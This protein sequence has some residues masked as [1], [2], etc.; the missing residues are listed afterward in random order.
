MNPIQSLESAA[1]NYLAIFAMTGIP[2]ESIYKG[3]ENSSTI[4][5]STKALPRVVLSADDCS[6]FV[7]YTGNYRGTLDVTVEASAFDTTDQAFDTIVKE[8]FEKFA[9]SDLAAQL[10]AALSPFNCFDARA[11][12]TA[13]R[14]KEGANWQSTLN[15][16]VHF[17]SADLV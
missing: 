15:I 3:I 14:I 10:S 9:V 13:H 16:D 12:S 11:M 6:E 17:C 1:F 5:E 4:D 2:V 7:P 8:V